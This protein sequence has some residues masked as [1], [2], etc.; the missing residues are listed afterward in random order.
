MKKK[1]LSL[2]ALAISLSIPAFAQKM[3]YGPKIVA[4]Q[5]TV[6]DPKFIMNDE[7]YASFGDSQ[8]YG[9]LTYNYGVY[10]RYQFN[11]L[12][13]QAEAL[14]ASYSS[15]MTFNGRPD[16]S[17]YIGEVEIRRANFT[18]MMQR[19]EI[20]TLAGV[21]LGAF[22]VQAGFVSAVPLQASLKYSYLEMVQSEEDPNSFHSHTVSGEVNEK[23]YYNNFHLDGQLGV[24]VTIMKRVLIGLDYQTNLTNRRESIAV[25]DQSANPGE[26][27]NSVGL[28]L[29]VN[30]GKK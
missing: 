11:R 26:K 6:T 27:M 7:V 15:N 21:R 20:P 18:S 8:F 28:W 3:S 17:S 9:N 22:W 10:T 23:N 19:L 29:A 2:L 5:A 30:L 13:L 4:H 25:L 14:Y 12:Y 16:E 24:G 1:V